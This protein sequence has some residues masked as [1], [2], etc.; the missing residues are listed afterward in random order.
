[1][2]T[3]FSDGDTVIVHKQDDFESGKICVVLIN[4]DEATV[5]KVYKLEDGIEGLVHI[6]QLC[7][8][9]IAKPEEKFKVGQCVNAKI[10]DINKETNKM[11]LSIKDLEGTSDEYIEN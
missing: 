3:V 4:G 1:M 8:E 9:H 2:E 10:I 11:E 7:E 5:K 6:S